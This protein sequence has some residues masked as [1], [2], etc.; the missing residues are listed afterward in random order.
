M[1]MVTVICRRFDHQHNSEEFFVLLARRSFGTK[2]LGKEDYIFCL[3]ILDEWS[4]FRKK[5]NFCKMFVPKEG[6]ARNH[7]P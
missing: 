5:F 7:L 2:A 3:V 4:A 1:A 6:D